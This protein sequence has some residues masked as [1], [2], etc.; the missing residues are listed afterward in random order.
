MAKLAGI[1]YNRPFYSLED[2]VADY[3]G[4]YLLNNKYL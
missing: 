3:V 1:G 4:N 2:G